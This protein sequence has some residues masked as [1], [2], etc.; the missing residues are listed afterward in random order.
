MFFIFVDLRQ[1]QKFFDGELFP[2]YGTIYGIWYVYIF[3]CDS[4]LNQI[5]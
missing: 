1:R 3:V 4:T 2:N 5:T